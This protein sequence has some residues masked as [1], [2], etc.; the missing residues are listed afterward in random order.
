[1]RSGRRS[2]CPPHRL[3]LGVLVRPKKVAGA[4][5]Q[6]LVELG[7]V[8]RSR[9]REMAGRRRMQGM[10]KPGRHGELD[11][12]PLQPHLDV[13]GGQAQPLG[14]QLDGP[15]QLAAPLGAIGDGQLRRLQL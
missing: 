2:L 13:G 5:Q 4:V 8:R 15:G 14:R 12:L 10:G 7:L 3:L 6:Q 1:M 9:G 11:A